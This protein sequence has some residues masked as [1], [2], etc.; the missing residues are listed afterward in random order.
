MGEGD[1]SA[2]GSAGVE[3]THTRQRGN[4]PHRGFE[5]GRRPSKGEQIH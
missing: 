4:K 3:K 2:H 5:A 1:F